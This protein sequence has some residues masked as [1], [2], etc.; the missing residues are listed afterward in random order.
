MKLSA[1]SEGGV[2]SLSSMK[3]TTHSQAVWEKMNWVSGK[4]CKRWRWKIIGEEYEGRGER[5]VGNE[6]E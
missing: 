5:V 4:G 3:R 1:G 6:R 2:S